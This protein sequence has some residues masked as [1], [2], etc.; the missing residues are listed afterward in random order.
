[1]ATPKKSTPES[2]IKA[3][4]FIQLLLGGKTRQAAY[5]ECFPEETVRDITTINRQSLAY[6]QRA[7]VQIFYH[8]YKDELDR[9][10]A[11]NIYWT[12]EKAVAELQDLITKSKEQYDRAKDIR[13]VGPIIIQAVTTLNKMFGYDVP[14]GQDGNTP[15][16]VAFTFVP[17]KKPEPETLPDELKEKQNEDENKTE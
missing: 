13:G 11:K 2:N 8:K 14:D 16:P 4:K 17:V 15:V 12:R 10:A 9:K 3:E 6:F 5:R 1:M 7:E